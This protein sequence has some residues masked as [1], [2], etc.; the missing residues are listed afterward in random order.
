M[1]DA[2]GGDKATCDCVVALRSELDVK[3]A[4]HGSCY[5]DEF[6][7][8]CSTVLGFNFFIAHTLL[9]GGSF[10]RTTLFWFFVVKLESGHHNI[11]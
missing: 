3:L 2:W 5:V 6:V 11:L 7:D 1:F 9:F 10:Y 8:G 4:A